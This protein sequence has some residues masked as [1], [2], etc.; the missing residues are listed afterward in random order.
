MKRIP[1]MICLAIA[2]TAFTTGYSSLSVGGTPLWASLEGENERPGPGDP[3]G[4]GTFE[5]TLNQGQGTLTYVLT[6]D[7]IAPAT[8]AH[9]HVAPPTAP[10]PVLIGLMAPTSGIST[11]TIN[12]KALFPNDWKE[13]IKDLR[14]NPDAYYVNVHNAEYPAGAIRGQLSR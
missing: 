13:V 14:K 12:L 11:G 8:A 10:G 1:L 6:A 3:D 2:V 9:I 5:M 7:D 4:T